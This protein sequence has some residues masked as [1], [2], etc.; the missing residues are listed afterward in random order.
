[1]AVQGLG[2]IA[3]MVLLFLGLMWLLGSRIRRLAAEA[4]RRIQAVSG[5][6]LLAGGSFF[7]FYWGLSFLMD[8]GRWGF[9]LGWYG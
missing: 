2:Q 6:A 4:P 5:F 9:K 1:M 3:V 8:I 7:V